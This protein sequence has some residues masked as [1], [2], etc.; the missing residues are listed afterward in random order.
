MLGSWQFATRK[1]H[2]GQQLGHVKASI[3]TLELSLCVPV[4]YE[5]LQMDL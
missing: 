2:H 1:G 3:A 5:L 4:C